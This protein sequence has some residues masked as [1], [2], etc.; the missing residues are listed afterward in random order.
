MR[1]EKYKKEIITFCK[2]S[3]GIV[4]KREPSSFNGDV[5]I[6]KYKITI[7]EIEEPKEILCK[8]LEELWTHENNFHQYH[9]LEKEAKK[10]DYEFKGEFGKKEEK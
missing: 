8:R 3:F 9:L 7:E 2:S 6:K 4:E 1:D 10:L 5:E